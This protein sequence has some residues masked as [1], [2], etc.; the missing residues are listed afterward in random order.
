[1]EA[2]LLSA[3]A[4]FAGTDHQTDIYFNCP[5]GRLKL[6]MGNIENNL[7]FYNRPDEKGPKQSTFQLVPVANGA[8]MQQLLTTAL[9]VRATVEKKRRIYF[10]DNIKVHLDELEGLGYFVEIEAGNLNHPS[11]TA[12]ELHQQCTQLMQD[13]GIEQHH[14]IHKSYGDMV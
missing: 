10:L 3:N 13:M 9:G 2:F 5:N 7:I 6:R 8:L 4:R 1:V 14:L 12:A 11:K